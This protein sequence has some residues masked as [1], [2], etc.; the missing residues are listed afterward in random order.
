MVTEVNA[1]PAG[2]V[3][4]ATEDDLRRLLERGVVEIIPR[5]PLV[6]KLRAGERLRLY[7][8]VDPTSPVIHLGHAV[9]LRKL[10]QFQDLGHEVV[11]LIGDFTGRIGDPTDR[12]ATRVQ[13]TR[14][15]VLANAQTYREQAAKILD[16]DS[17]TNPVQ[18][19]YNGDWWDRMTARDMIE[20]AALFTVN[21]MLQH[22]TYAKRLEEGR[23]LGLHEMLY[24]LLQGYDSVALDTD[25]E[26]GGTDQ[27][28]NMLAGRDMLLRLKGKEKVVITCPLLEG[29]DG[30]KMS[31][32]FGNVIGVTDPPY[33]MYGRVMSLKDELIVRYF[34]LAT[35]VPDEELHEIERQLREQ[36]VNPMEIKKRL[37]REIVTMYH[38]AEA[39]LEAERRFEREV[40]HREIPE[41][42]PEVFIGEQTTWHIAD[43]LVAAGLVAGKNEAKR[44]VQQGSVQLDGKRVEDP[45]A[46][47]TVHDGAVLRARKRSFARLRLQSR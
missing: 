40:Q 13:L 19:R 25:V 27:K 44:L 35:D 2:R 21:Q 11:L 16:F 9:P 6:A 39:A 7:M 30:R 33:E 36:L 47:V 5:E 41:E 26:V 14:E 38:S 37:A 8:G 15:Q 31:K 1:P 28:F 45:L 18:V 12:S 22:E 43:L 4:P 20:L 32:S 10:R 17:P 29:T 23:P 46:Q 34:E 42:M 24:P 3:Q